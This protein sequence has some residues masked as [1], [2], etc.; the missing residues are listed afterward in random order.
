MIINWEISQTTK[1]KITEEPTLPSYLSFLRV[2]EVPW[3]LPDP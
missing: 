3:G 1:A 2:N